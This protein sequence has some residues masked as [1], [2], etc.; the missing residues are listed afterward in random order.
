[1]SVKIATKCYWYEKSV[2][3]PPYCRLRRNYIED[4]GGCTYC[5]MDKDVVDVFMQGL[6]NLMLN[7]TESSANCRAFVINTY[8]MVG[9]YIFYYDA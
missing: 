8:V 3:D 2:N 6:N 1:M 5:Y 9:A 4:I 7:K